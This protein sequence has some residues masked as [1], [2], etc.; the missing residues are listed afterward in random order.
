MPRNRGGDEYMVTQTLNDGLFTCLIHLDPER[1]KIPFRKTPHLSM[2]IS[3]GGGKVEKLSLPCRW[4]TPDLLSVK[5]IVPPGAVVN[6]AL[7]IEGEAPLILAPAVQSISPE[8]AGNSQKNLIPLIRAVGGRIRSSFDDMGRYLPRSR[9]KKSIL[10]HCLA[11]AV[12]LLLLQVFCRRSG[13]E[14]KIPALKL[15]RFKWERAPRERVAPR[16]K[17]QLSVTVQ[18]EEDIVVS[19]TMSSALKRAKKK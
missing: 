8:L 2:L 7:E 17:E 4:E 10:P 12:I 5:T 9:E 1:Q 13:T 3:K 16:K 18:K 14:I 19:D 11:A 6:A 15:P